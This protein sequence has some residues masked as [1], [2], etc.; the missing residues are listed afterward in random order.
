MDG[1]ISG[2]N[3]GMKKR[4]KAKKVIYT[5]KWTEADVSTLLSMMKRGC[6]ANECSRKLN[7]TSTAIRFKAFKL[8]ISFTRRGKRTLPGWNGRRRRK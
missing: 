5:N 8:Q 4:R 6:N 1:W 7:R 2:Y 3:T